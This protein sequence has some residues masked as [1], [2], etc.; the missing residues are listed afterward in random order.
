[1]L[2]P[3]V[4]EQQL[5][6]LSRPKPLVERLGAQF[7]RTIPKCPGVYLMRDGR[8]RLLYVG[9]AGNLRQRVGSYRYI[10]DRTSRRTIR[11]LHAVETITWELCESETAACLRENELL[12]AHRPKYN[13]ANT[14]PKAYPFIDLRMDATVIDLRLTQE[15]S[16]H[17]YGAF[18]GNA[19]GGFVAL[20]RLLWAAQHS[21]HDYACLPR[22]MLLERTPG[23]WSFPFQ[24]E[25]GN[26]LAGLL[27]GTSDALI[28][29]LETAPVQMLPGF[30]AQ[31][32]ASDL[33]V[34][35]GFYERGP[36]RNSRWL[37]QTQ[38]AGRCIAQERL[39]DLTVLMRKP[40]QPDVPALTAP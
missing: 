12:H 1:M 22:Q 5:R 26:A 24:E 15:E 38:G 40:P 11:L 17:S 33:E 7:F 30:Y 29:A 28:R 4:P 32:R 23:E 9:K 18:K 10:T 35:A 20:L 6:L 16:Q 25:L 14:F 27:S 37:A 13:R 39:D 19:R 3:V 21:G 34:L 31:F 8:Q 2:T 36:L